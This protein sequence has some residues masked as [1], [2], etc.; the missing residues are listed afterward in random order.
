MDVLISGAIAAFVAWVVA[1]RRIATHHITAE[2]RKWR[3]EVRRLALEVHDAIRDGDKFAMARLRSEFRARLNPDDEL[4]NNLLKHMTVGTRYDWEARADK[5][6][7]LISRMLK[8]DWERAKREASFLPFWRRKWEREQGRDHLGEPLPVIAV[9]WAGLMI[10]TTIIA[11]LYLHVAVAV[12]PSLDIC[13]SLDCFT[14]VS[15]DSFLI[16]EPFS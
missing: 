12:P 5:F 4:D 9:I 1:L 7:Y 10:P 13:C 6:A 3:E 16:V 8:H 15:A 2:R 14:V 11:L